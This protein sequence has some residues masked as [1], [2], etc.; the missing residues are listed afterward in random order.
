VAAESKGFGEKFDRMGSVCIIASWFSNLILK[1][2]AEVPKYR[3]IKTVAL[4]TAAVLAVGGSPVSGLNMPANARGPVAPL[5]VPAGPANTVNPGAVLDGNTTTPPTSQTQARVP[6]ATHERRRSGDLVG[7]VLNGKLPVDGT[8]GVVRPIW[9]AQKSNGVTGSHADRGVGQ[10]M[11]GKVNGVNGKHL[12]SEWKGPEKTDVDVRDVVL[13]RVLER[14]G[15]QKV[16]GSNI[17]QLA[18]LVRT[19]LIEELR[20]MGRG[21]GVRELRSVSLSDVDLSRFVR[22]EMNTSKTDKRKGYHRP[23]HTLYVDFNSAGQVTYEL[24]REFLGDA[25]GRGFRGRGSLDENG[26]NYSED[27]IDEGFECT[28]ATVDERRREEGIAEQWERILQSQERFI[29]VSAQTSFRFSDPE[30]FDWKYRVFDANAWNV[31]LDEDRNLAYENWDVLGGH[32]EYELQKVFYEPKPHEKA[33]PEA[34]DPKH[35]ANCGGNYERRLEKK[36]AAELEQ[37][38][39]D[40]SGL[41]AYRERDLKQ[42]YPEAFVDLDEQKALAARLKARRGSDFSLFS[43]TEGDMDAYRDQVQAEILED[44]LLAVVLEEERFGDVDQTGDEWYAVGTDDA[45]LDELWGVDDEEEEPS[46][47]R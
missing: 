15:E 7:L 12:S 41:T 22:K 29:R 38:A 13:D 9:D 39:A 45:M 23:K 27:A 4:G 8:D 2:M 33:Y 3:A 31:G 21:W 10:R 44:D 43:A 6:V 18:D 26:L 37:A 46:E 28:M 30:H 42:R 20:A 5:G 35:S 36:Y 19:T 11:N 1:L 17:R 16:T 24:I 40:G 25:A 34:Y 32:E 47:S 14:F